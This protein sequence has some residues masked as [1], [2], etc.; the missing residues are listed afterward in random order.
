M[1]HISCL[2]VRETDVRHWLESLPL[3]AHNVRRPWW[4]DKVKEHILKIP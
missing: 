3:T 4:K 2:E 1:E